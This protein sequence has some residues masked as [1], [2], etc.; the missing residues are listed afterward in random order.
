MLA[1]EI[2][3]QLVTTLKENPTLSV[4][5]KY[6][7]E[8]IRYDVTGDNFPCIMLE[9]TGN[10]EVEK[11]FNTVKDLFLNI[12]LLAFSSPAENDFTKSIVGDD[13]YKGILDIENDIR[14]CLQSSYDLGGT[15]ID[16]RL[17][18]TSFDN[19]PFDGMK[20]PIRG[21]LIPVKIL[22]RQQDGT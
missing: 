14:A 2:W 12:N 9:P 7:Y 5:V 17:D 13:S 1:S 4:Y 3:T 16:T 19:L 6:V 10:N 11:D 21:M 22:Y 20:H 18:P 8:G 15:V